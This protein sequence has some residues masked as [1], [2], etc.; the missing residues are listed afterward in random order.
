MSIFVTRRCWEDI[1][2]AEGFSS[3]LLLRRFAFP[4][5]SA[6]V[7]CTVG[8][9]GA[10]IHGL[11]TQST[12]SLVTLQ[13]WPGDHLATVLP[14]QTSHTSSP[15][16]HSSSPLPLH[17]PRLS[18]PEPWRAVSRG[19]PNPNRAAPGLPPSGDLAPFARLFLG[20]LFCCL[21]WP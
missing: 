15:P 8:C 10:D 14:V 11:C 21:V 20:G 5:L 9:G 17:T 19:P 13:P 12:A 7:S 2:I 3:R 1:A 4:C 6:A 18:L 16:T